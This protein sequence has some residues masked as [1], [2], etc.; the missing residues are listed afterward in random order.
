MQFFDIVKHNTTV[1]LWCFNDRVQ[2]FNN[3]VVFRLFQI[4]MPYNIILYFRL[5]YFDVLNDVL[6]ST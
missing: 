1:M 5:P 6:F 4:L 3:F 2:M